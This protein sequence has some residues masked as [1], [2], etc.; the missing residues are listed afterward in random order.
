[1]QRKTILLIDDDS[2]DAEFFAD[3]LSGFVE[4][5]ILRCAEG[6]GQALQLL[7]DMETLP[8]LI[9]LDA[10]MPKMNGWECLKLL[11]E[12]SRFKEIPVIMT[13]TSSR[14]QGIDEARVLGAE[15]YIIKPFDF[16]DLKYLIQS[17]CSGLEGR[18]EEVLSALESEKPQTIFFFPKN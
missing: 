7:P 11:K 9:L 12:D 4:D 5:I 18:L 10:G 14:R 2:D 17:I 6:G 8:E 13:A 3:A 16:N 1:M 15:A